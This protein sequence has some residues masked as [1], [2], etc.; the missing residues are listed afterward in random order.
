MIFESASLSPLSEEQHAQALDYYSAKLSIRDRKKLIRVLCHQ[1]PDQLTAAIRDVLGVYDPLIRSIH[2]GVDLT[3]GLGDL[4]NFLDDTIKTVKPNENGKAA[5]SVEDFLVLFRRHLPSCLR[6]L[7]Q[8]AKNCPDVAKDFRAYCKDAVKRF[9]GND[10]ARRE[11]VDRGAGAMKSDLNELCASIPEEQHDPIFSALDAHAAYLSSLS[12]LSTA[13]AQAVLDNESSTMYGPGVYLAR[14]HN[15]LDET[16]ITPQEPEGNVRKGIDVRF[17]EEEGK[18]KAS[19]KSWWDSA[20]IAR[21]GMSDV[22]EAP[23]VGVVVELLGERWVSMFR[24][25][26]DSREET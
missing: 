4:Q 21:A 11:G 2:N 16:L 15:L 24:C 14:W 3:A 8:V 10:P 1:H 25:G 12:Q 26:N 22:P 13:R 17:K 9:R 23:D 19:A 7:H 20:D 5:P 6:F 18:R